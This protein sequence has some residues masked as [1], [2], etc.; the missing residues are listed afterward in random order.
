V[1]VI[2]ENRKLLPSWTVLGVEELG[3]FSAE[4]FEIKVGANTRQACVLQR[5]PGGNR[6]DDLLD[7]EVVAV[8]QRQIT[9]APSEV[10]EAEFFALEFAAW[11]TVHVMLAEELFQV[12]TASNANT[13]HACRQRHLQV[14]TLQG[15]HG[16]N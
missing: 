14:P 12:D 3:Y 2:P 16:L 11:K 10:V 6:R 13:L 4:Q 7:V 5:Q 15:H 1:F 9:W 8:E